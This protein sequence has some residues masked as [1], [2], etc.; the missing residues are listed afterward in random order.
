MR[1]INLEAAIGRYVERGELAGAAMLVWRNGEAQVTCVGRR[2]LDRSL[3]VERDT[4]FRI[5]S[6]TK[7][8]TSVLALMLCEAGRF[9]LDEPIARWA[10]EFAKMQVLRAPNG[11]LDATEPASRAIT[12]RD[13]LSHRA[14]LTYGDFHSGPIAAAYAK[15]LGGDIDSE[16]TP[17]DWITS[18][19]ALPLID[20]P[21]HEFHY[22]KSTD[23][24]GLLIERIEDAPLA[25][26]MQRRIF[27]PL[28]M[29]NTFFTVPYADRSRC[30]GLH[31]F[32]AN[33]R[34]ASLQT[35]PG[36]HAL[37]VRPDDMALVSGGQGLWSTLDD[38]LAFARLFVEGGASGGVRLLRPETLKLIATN[39]LTDGQR[40]NSRLLG[41]ALFAQGHGFGLGVAVV[42]EPDKADPTR[43]GGGAGSVG[44]PGAYGGW[45]QA[46]P[47]DGSV[48]V[49]L[50][51]NMVRLDQLMAGIGLGVWNAI[52]DFQLIGSDPA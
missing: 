52:Q 4:I 16:V 3:P 48:M 42:M 44:W 41:Q 39:C 14:G 5:A 11:P 25:Q 32:D 21:G 2:D 27:E 7:P 8:V 33:G 19:A 26:I 6:M 12:F 49:F 34:L 37:A 15:A 43:C 29:K 51:H 46:D 45:W 1:N 30:A 47:N 35:V 17:S 40:A 28:G 38:Y 22:G 10:S 13:L 31:G 24:L 20:Q 9:G 23:L 18:L 50:A 36:G